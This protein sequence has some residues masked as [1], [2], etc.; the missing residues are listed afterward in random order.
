MNQREL[1]KEAS[2]SLSL[3]SNPSG[4]LGAHP[5]LYNLSNLGRHRVSAE[6]YQYSRQRAIAAWEKAVTL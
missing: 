1:E 6:N 2:T 5:A 4:F 3:L